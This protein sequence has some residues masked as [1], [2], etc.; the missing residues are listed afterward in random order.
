M[1]TI[2]TALK[3]FISLIAIAAIVAGGIWASTYATINSYQA[4]D[5]VEVLPVVEKCDSTCQYEKMKAELVDNY[6]NEHIE[7]ALR[8]AETTAKM[9][10]RNEAEMKALEAIN[11]QVA[12]DL[13]D[14]KG[15]GVSASVE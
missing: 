5:I 1:K 8:Q 13:A 3:W 12:E 6:Y 10:V 4:E 15:V 2:K 14:Y 9:R 11:N 7:A